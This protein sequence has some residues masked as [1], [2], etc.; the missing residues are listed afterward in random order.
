MPNIH[1][2]TSHI[3]CSKVTTFYI[4]KPSVLVSKCVRYAHQSFAIIQ[5][6]KKYT[7]RG[8]CILSKLYCTYQSLRISYTSF[9]KIHQA[10]SVCTDSC[11][12]VTG[13]SPELRGR[14][15]GAGGRCT[16]ALPDQKPNIT[17]SLFAPKENLPQRTSLL[18]QARGAL[19][20]GCRTLLGTGPRGPRAARQSLPA[21]LSVKSHP[22]PRR[23]RGRRASSAQQPR[24]LLRRAAPAPPPRLTNRRRR[25]APPPAQNGGGRSRPQTPPGSAGGAAAGPARSAGLGL[26]LGPAG[27]V[28]TRQNRIRCSVCNKAIITHSRETLIISLRVARA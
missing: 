15:A 26:R 10:V 2:N 14:T 20:Q 9:L 1:C 11:V 16:A 19:T 7:K 28:L 8:N 25:P 12:C 27:A 23:T 21:L 4:L 18:S 6:V 22:P 3:K 5:S 24:P 17:I 13:S